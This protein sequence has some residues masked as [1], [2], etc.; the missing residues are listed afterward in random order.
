MINSIIA[1]ISTTLDSAFGYEVYDEEIKQGLEE[2]CF[3][4]KCLNPTNSLFLGRRYYRVNNF[5]IQYFPKSEHKPKAEC[6]TVAEQLMQ[7]LESIPVLD[8]VLRGTE[9]KF[10]VIDGI[11]NFF[12]NY[13]CFVYKVEHKTAMKTLQSHKTNVKG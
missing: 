6:Y 12:V 9:M 11:L 3:F 4:I 7:C 5:V 10:E 1:G 13:N 8:E 2:P